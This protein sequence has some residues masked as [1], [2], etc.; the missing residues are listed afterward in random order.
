MYSVTKLHRTQFYKPGQQQ[1]DSERSLDT[2]VFRET[3]L[4]DF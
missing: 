4:Q 2:L 1:L 3:A